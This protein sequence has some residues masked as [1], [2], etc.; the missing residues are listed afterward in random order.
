MKKVIDLTHKIHDGMVTF[1]GI[2]AVKINTYMSRKQTSEAYGEK[3]QSLL[4]RITMVNINGTYVDAPKHRSDDGY[5]V[6]DIPLIKCVDLDYEVIV[7]KSDKNYFDLDDV[8]GHGIENGGI[9]LCS[10]HSDKFETDEYGINPPYLTP[11]AARYLVDRGVVFVGIDSPLID[12][13]NHLSDIGCPTHD[14]I[15]SSGGIVCEDMTNLEN[16][17]NYQRKGK[18]FASPP[19]VEM[20]SFTTRAYILVKGD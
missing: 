17:I 14:I 4:D 15:L 1:P 18:L 9:L 5:Y 2:P 16:A 11:K 20:A 3:G 8:Y 19:K 13:M 12:D 10:Y 6:C 7:M